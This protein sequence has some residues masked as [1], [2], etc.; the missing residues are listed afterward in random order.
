MA[1]Q[2]KVSQPQKFISVLLEKVLED[3]GTPP[4][5]VSC[6]EFNFTFNLNVYILTESAESKYI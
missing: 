1:A 3:K 2:R 6:R 4:L 5:K